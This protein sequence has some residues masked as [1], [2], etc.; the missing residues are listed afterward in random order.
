MWRL[1]ID[2]ARTGVENMAV[3]EALLRLAERQANSRQTVLR[4]YKWSQPTLSLGY[5]QRPEEAADL[6]LCASYGISIVRRPTGGRAVLHDQELTY[7]VVSNDPRFFNMGL[8]QC[9]LTSAYLR[10]GR[11]L[12]SALA[13]LGLEAT[14]H[15]SGSRR[16]RDPETRRNRLR[17]RSPCFVTAAKHEILCRG[18]KII[19]SAQRRLRA[20]FLQHGSLL[21]DCDFSLLAAVTR[22][23]EEVLKATLTTIKDESRRRIEEEEIILSFKRAFQE[24]FGAE[25]VDSSLREDEQIEAKRLMQEG[26]YQAA[27]YDRPRRRERALMI[28]QG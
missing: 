4:I 22:T 2:R 27:S 20:S 1:I 6:E 15:S 14:I 16:K 24:E 19:G 18:K 28:E 17:L 9:A 25:L 21:L 12:K 10:I 7:S 13:S 5:T 26:W 11:A 3:D 8:S 23:D